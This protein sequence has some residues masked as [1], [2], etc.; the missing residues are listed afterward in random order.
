MAAEREMLEDLL[1]DE[2]LGDK[3]RKAF[4]GML[5]DLG[6]QGLSQKQL[7]WV[8]DRWEKLELGV[9]PSLNLFSSGKVKGADPG[10]PN[11][12]RLPWERDGYVKPLKPPGK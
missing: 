6:P 2:R 1:E 9:G 10:S 12:V 11:A 8:Q 5:D 4:A 3:E 7:A